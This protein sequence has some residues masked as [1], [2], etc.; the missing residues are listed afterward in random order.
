MNLTLKKYKHVT[1]YIILAGYFFLFGYNI[2]HF[3][4]YNVILSH[5]NVLTQKNDVSPGSSHSVNLDFQCPVHNIYTSLHNVLL[6]SSNLSTIT[7]NKIELFNSTYF[8]FFFQKEFHLSN[9]LRAP[10]VLFS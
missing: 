10:P 5:S 2:L 8:Q 1:A 6:Q 3:H 7:L 9:A 4:H